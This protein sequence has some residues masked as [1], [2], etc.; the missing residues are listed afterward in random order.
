MQPRLRAM[1]K[2]YHENNK[3]QNNSLSLSHKDNNNALQPFQRYESKAEMDS[4]ADAR[5]FA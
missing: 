2:A 3:K 4:A 5:E 1:L